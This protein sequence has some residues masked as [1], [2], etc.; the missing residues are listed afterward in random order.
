MGTSVA[1]QKRISKINLITRVHFYE[2]LCVL[3]CEI[4]VLLMILIV[5]CRKLM[6]SLPLIAAAPSLGTR[7]HSVG[8]RGAGQSYLVSLRGNFASSFFSPN[9]VGDVALSLK[10][11]RNKYWYWNIWK[12]AL[13]SNYSKGNIWDTISDYFGND[14]RIFRYDAWIFEIRLQNI[15]DKIPEYLRYDTRIFEIRFHKIWDTIPEYLNYRLFFWK[16]GEIFMM[17]NNW[18]MNYC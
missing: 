7:P 12:M 9:Q 8:G 13:V 4:S 5:P 2:V 16:F 14:S 18:I 10:Y 3:L 1:S 6:A 15:W 11:Y 17:Q